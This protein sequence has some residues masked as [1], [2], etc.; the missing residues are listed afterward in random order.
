M[1]FDSVEF[2]LFL[3]LVTVVHWLCPS[4]WRW[5]VLLAASYWFYMSWNAALAGLIAG[6]TLAT[7]GLALAIARSRGKVRTLWLAAAVAVCLGVLAFFK[8]WNFLGESGAA[9]VRLL[10]GTGHWQAMDIVLP[11]GISFYTF[12]A[13]SYVADVYRGKLAAQRH[14]GYY[15]LYISF[16]P[17]LVAGPIERAGDLLPQL[18]GERRLSR[19]DLA[20]GTRLILGGLVRKLVIADLCGGF[21]TA[22]YESAG[23]PDGSAVFAATVLFAAQIY[24]DFAGYSLI[25]AG[26][27]R[28]LGVRLMRNFDRP[29]GAVNIRDF[30]RRWHISLTGWFTDYVYIPLGGSR[31]GALRQ[32]AATMA[33]FLLSGLWHGADWTFAV[34]G[35]LHG[36]YMLPGLLR[37]RYAPAEAAPPGRLRRAGSRLAT[38]TAVGFAWIFFRAQSM[39]RAWA[40]VKSLFSPWHWPAGAALLGM[41]AAQVLWLALA[42]ALTPALVRLEEENGRLSD[43]TYVYLIMAVVLAWLIRAQS[44]GGNQFIYFQF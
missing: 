39:D 21:V 16:F 25:A 26:S 32:A 15:A 18:T 27:A 19:V 12:Q 20:A 28:L 34:W 4:R 30:W 23:V 9:L 5:A 14:P 3:P 2:L 42:A 11:V 6:V 29:Y 17:Q 36:C 44:G 7:Y 40:L 10:G 8:Y 43:M 38:L 37:R 41:G 22:V 24:N 13:L 1:S 31:R 35:L 33:V